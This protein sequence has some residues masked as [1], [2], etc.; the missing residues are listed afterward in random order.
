[1]R[2]LRLPRGTAVLCLLSVFLNP[3]VFA[4]VVHGTVVAN[5]TG[6]PLARSRIVIEAVNKGAPGTTRSVLTGSAGQ[7]VFEDLPAGAY[8]LSASRPGFAATKYGQQKWNTQGTPVAL[9]EESAFMAEIR[10]KKLGVITGDLLDENQVG[11]PDHSVHVYKSGTRLALVAGAQTNDAG[12]YRIAGLA[13]GRYYVRTGA[14]ELEDKQG[15]LPTYFGQTLGAREARSIEVDLDEERAGIDIAPIPGKLVSVKGTLMG[16]A[17]T[18]ALYGD[19]GRREQNVSSGG[20]FAFDQLAPGEYR[21]VA[22][23]GAGENLLTAYRTFS[24]SRPLEHVSLELAPAPRVGITCTERRGAPLETRSVSV[25]VRRK[26]PPEDQSRRVACSQEIPLP[27]G[28]WDLAALPPTGFYVSVVT[29]AT[30]ADDSHEF[31]L[32]SDRKRELNIVLSS[33]PATLT[34]IVKIADGTPAI[35][36]PVFLKATDASVRSRLGG[37]TSV[38]TDQTGKYLFPGVPPGSY[39]AISSFDLQSGGNAEWEPGRGKSITLEEDADATLDLA[40]TE[41]N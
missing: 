27:P 39:E 32:A 33:Q 14:K 40:L 26:E 20:A 41:L 28:I 8:L 19:T 3:P 17:A 6:R 25:F 34:G 36:A 11:L 38:R 29:G 7:F 15:L 9:E 18:V 10:L 22:E 4:A 16:P 23:S 21:L 37:V 2:R 1:M 12:T 35:G 5:R 30:A 31:T 13:P 24:V